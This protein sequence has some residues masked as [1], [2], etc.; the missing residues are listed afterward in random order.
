MKIYS[1]DKE[2]L[3]D[4]GILS[5]TVVAS[6]IEASGSPGLSMVMDVF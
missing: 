4:I 3:K 5:P 6:L 1:I 2:E